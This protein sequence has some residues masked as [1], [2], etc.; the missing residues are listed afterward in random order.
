MTNRRYA[1]AL[2]QDIV[3]ELRELRF[4]TKY[5]AVWLLSAVEEMS[6]FDRAIWLQEDQC[7][8]DLRDEYE[9]W[10]TWSDWDFD[11]FESPAMAVL[12]DREQ[13]D[14]F[15]DQRRRNEIEAFKNN[16]LGGKHDG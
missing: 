9:D 10:L 3:E 13:D 5:G 8:E 2:D 11:A 16:W 15:A 7:W 1:A 14:M 6:L 12:R 4:E